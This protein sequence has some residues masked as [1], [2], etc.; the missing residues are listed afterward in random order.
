MTDYHGDPEMNAS[1]LVLFAMAVLIVFFGLT[2]G[3]Q[4][5]KRG[6]SVQWEFRTMLFFRS[7]RSATSVT[8]QYVRH[9]EWRLSSFIL[10]HL[11]GE[12]VKETLLFGEVA[13]RSTSST[14]QIRLPVFRN[15]TPAQF[16]NL[17]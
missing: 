6:D 13:A 2:T 12:V 7:R 17:I 10:W 3:S 11:E 15:V 8:R 4:V 9:V 5:S 1:A 16:Q 14:A